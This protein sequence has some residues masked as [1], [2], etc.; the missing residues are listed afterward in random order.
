VDTIGRSGRAIADGIASAL[1]LQKTF[2]GTLL[3]DEKLKALLFRL[4]RNIEATQREM[5]TLFIVE[6]H[7]KKKLGA[8]TLNRYRSICP[9][10]VKPVR[11]RR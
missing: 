5:V 4:D 11:Q 8:D 9:T 10:V 2:G 1:L 6:E 3:E 7:I